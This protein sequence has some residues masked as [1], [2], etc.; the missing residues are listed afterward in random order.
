MVLD[1]PS[2]LYN[3]KTSFFFVSGDGW[4]IIPGVNSDDAPK[5]LC[6][7]GIPVFVCPFIH[8][9]YL[10]VIFLCVCNNDVP[11]LCRFYLSL[12]EEVIS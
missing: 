5:L 12:F 9:P 2:S 7:W 4:E 10:C 8:F 6:S 1:S 3:L 11:F